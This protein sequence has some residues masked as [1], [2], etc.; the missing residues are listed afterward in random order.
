L[1][2]IGERNQIVSAVNSRYPGTEKVC[3][4]R[5]GFL[6]YSTQKREEPKKIYHTL[7]ELQQDLDEWV[8][9]YNT[10]RT[11]Q[12]KRCDG[13]TPMETFLDGKKIWHE[14]VGN[15]NLN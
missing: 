3:S 15:L 6:I 10:Q 8:A 4:T 13:R 14:K 1:L 11:H 2:W 9:H 12:G 7:A 5:G